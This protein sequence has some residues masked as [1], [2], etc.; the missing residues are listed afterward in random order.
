MFGLT[1]V[2]MC[3]FFGV[4]HIIAKN[5][6]VDVT[7]VI[8]VPVTPN[9]NRLITVSSFDISSDSYS[10]NYDIS[11]ILYSNYV[12]SYE[13]QFFVVSNNLTFNL[14]TSCGGV[15]SNFY[16]NNLGLLDLNKDDIT[17]EINLVV[18]EDEELNF[19]SEVVVN[20]YYGFTL[21]PEFRVEGLSGHYR[22][23]VIDDVISIKDLKQFFAL[24]SESQQQFL[25][26][27][28]NGVNYVLN[29]LDKYNLY[30]NSQ[31][32]LY[33][34]QQYQLGRE[35]AA[36]ALSVSGMIREIF[37]AP[38]SMFTNAFN[39][40]LPLPDGTSLNVGG[41]LTFFLTIGI[42]LTIVGLISK[43]GGR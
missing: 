24:L 9:I 16:D 10:V 14:L 4:G 20:G 5:D 7:P 26:G 43:I 3:S 31:Y 23:G 25:L 18:E 6:K 28:Q 36:H 35:S 33:G 40:V 39:F 2:S 29:N 37:R 41:I 32:I 21:E 15:S 19:Y 42:A 17:V 12:A 8:T 34:Q 22:I 38:V 30:T 13:L 27:Y 1:A 11:Y